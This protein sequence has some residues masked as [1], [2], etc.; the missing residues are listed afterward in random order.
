MSVLNQA[1]DGLFNVLIVLV[2]ALVRFG[3]RSREELYR[4][5]GAE[6]E[7]VDASH[8]TRTLTSLDRTR[9]LRHRRQRGRYSRTLPLRPGQVRG[10][11][12]D[13]AS[14]SSSNC[15]TFA[16]EQCAVLGKRRVEKR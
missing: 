11:R 12:R 5:C 14:Q 9:A 13:Q 16:A 6:V 2:R 1:S 4:A 10:Y 3:P 8:L 15:R 7:V